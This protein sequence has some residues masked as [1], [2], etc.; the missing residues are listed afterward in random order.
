V[1]SNGGKVRWIKLTDDDDTYVPRFGWIRE[2]WAWAEV[3]NRKQD[4]MDL[5]FIDAKSGKSAKC[6]RIG[7]RR[8]VEVNDNF[9]ILNPT[10]DRTLAFCGPVGA[11]DT[12]I[13]ISTVFNASD[14][15]ASDAKLERQLETGEYEV[16]R[17]TVWTRRRARF[18]LP[19]IK[20]IRG[21]KNCS[22]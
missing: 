16:L 10:G 21:R 3:L 11:T 20:E 22:P 18:S 12:P 6:S 5:Y 2:G 15:I 8:L 1:G 14:P 7:A 9:R 13:F 19:P 17:L 4:V